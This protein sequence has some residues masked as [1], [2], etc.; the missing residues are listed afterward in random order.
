MKYPETGCSLTDQKHPIDSCRDKTCLMYSRPDRTIGDH[1]DTLD[2][3][4]L[5]STTETNNLGTMAMRISFIRVRLTIQ[6]MEREAQKEVHQDNAICA[7]NLLC[8][9]LSNNSLFRMTSKMA[10]LYENGSNT[11][12]EQ[13]LQ[14]STT[15]L[16]TFRLSADSSIALS[17][18][19][20]F[21]N[22]LALLCQIAGLMVSCSGNVVPIPVHQKNSTMETPSAEQNLT[23]SSPSNYE[24]GIPSTY[25]HWLLPICFFHEFVDFVE[26][27]RRF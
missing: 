3:E 21:T 20:Y 13:D 27:F 2:E 10:Y 4:L 1:C 9:V 22:G 19:V 26:E 6:S 7:G 11:T 15:R 14:N 18:L 5:L 8:L 23:F 16:K 25:Y 17:M 24:N 12:K